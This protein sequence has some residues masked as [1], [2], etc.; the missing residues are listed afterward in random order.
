MRNGNKSS[1]AEQVLTE[2]LNLQ[3]VV[4]NFSSSQVQ[5]QHFG[6]VL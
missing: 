5:S 4:D 2:D 6:M 3:Q 1:L